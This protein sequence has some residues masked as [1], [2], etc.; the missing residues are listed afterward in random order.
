M[1][2]T[3]TIDHMTSPMTVAMVRVSAEM[4][5][6]ANERNINWWMSFIPR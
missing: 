6:E 2:T 5:K 3:A 1:P 4:T